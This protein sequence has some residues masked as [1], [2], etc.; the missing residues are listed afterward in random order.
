MFGLL[1]PIS[2]WLLH[3]PAL[4]SVLISTP[5]LY[6]APSCRPYAQSMSNFLTPPDSWVS[7]PLPVLS[8]STLS[9]AGG[10]LHNNEKKLDVAG[11]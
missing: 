10:C 4:R 2:D 7:L 11:R 5:L 3:D 9:A 6:P 1:L 8:Y